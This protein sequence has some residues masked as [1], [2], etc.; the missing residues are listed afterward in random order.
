MKGLHAV[1]LRPKNITN[2]EGG[3]STKE[4]L[5]RHLILPIRRLPNRIKHFHPVPH[6]AKCAKCGRP[7]LTVNQETG[8][9]C[10][11]CP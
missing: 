1:R 2:A 10:W 5:R 4:S 9:S 7:A 3:R 8:V 11:V 6:M